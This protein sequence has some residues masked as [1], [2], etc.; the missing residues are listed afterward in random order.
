MR[1][2]NPPSPRYFSFLLLAVTY[3]VS[4]AALKEAGSDK[5]KAVMEA[6]RCRAA[7]EDAERGQ[8]EARKELER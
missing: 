5:D 6:T 3:V 4:Q 7:T 2:D 8:A 1:D